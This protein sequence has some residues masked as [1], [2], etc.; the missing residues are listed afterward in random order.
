MRRLESNLK[1]L[2]DTKDKPITL[3]EFMSK[4]YQMRVSFPLWDSTKEDK[5]LKDNSIYSVN[6]N[7]KGI[8]FMGKDGDMRW[9]AI[10]KLIASKKLLGK[11]DIVI[12][13]GC[14]YGA[15]VNGIALAFGCISLGIDI[16]VDNC[17]EYAEKFRV[18]NASFKKYSIQDITKLRFKKKFKLVLF[19]YQS[20]GDIRWLKNKK[21]QLSFFRWVLENSEYLLINDPKNRLPF[22][23]NMFKEYAKANDRSFNVNYPLKIFKVPN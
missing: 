11:N 21:V 3:S 22:P 2:K 5:F 4:K 13:L 17:L 23:R 18:K 19:T 7:N 1:N 16:D 15:L 10:K 14:S 6:V 9:K 20:H 12:D 8:E